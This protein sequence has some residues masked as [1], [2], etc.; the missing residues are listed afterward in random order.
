[1]DASSH[2]L[3]ICWAPGN[4][5]AGTTADR[6]QDWTYSSGVERNPDKIEVVSSLLTRSTSLDFPIS[7]RLRRM[8]G[9]RIPLE[10]SNLIR[11]SIQLKD[12]AWG[13]RSQQP[14]PSGATVQQMQTVYGLNEDQKALYSGLIA[15]ARSQLDMAADSSPFIPYQVIDWAHVSLMRIIE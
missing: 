1:M 10:R 4:S 2:S 9:R 11:F 6:L 14:G 12:Q 3:T 5:G 13:H 7:P 8:V 15:E